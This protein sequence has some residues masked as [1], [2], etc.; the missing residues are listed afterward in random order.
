MEKYGDFRLVEV[1]THRGVKIEISRALKGRKH[2]DVQHDYR[3]R[4]CTE[5][6]AILKSKNVVVITVADTFIDESFAS[7]IE[8][9]EYARALIDSERDDDPNHEE[10][11][12]APDTP[13][14]PPWQEEPPKAPSADAP[15][16]H[17]R[18]QLLRM[19]KQAGWGKKYEALA[20]RGQK[21]PEKK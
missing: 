16:L 10:D 11:P 6:K 5:C 12:D 15:N 19:I 17:R 20:R 4:A 1:A 7:I 21:P 2:C 8:A 14:D 3:A 9:A 13:P 18:A